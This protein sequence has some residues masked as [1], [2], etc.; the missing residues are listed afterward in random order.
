MTRPLSLERYQALTD[1]LAKDIR[2]LPWGAGGQKG[3]VKRL[4]GLI[5][6]NLKNATRQQRQRLEEALVEL[7]AALAIKAS[8]GQPDRTSDALA[9]WID[10]F[11]VTLGPDLLATPERRQ[12]WLDRSRDGARRARGKAR[13]VRHVKIGLAEEQWAKIQQLGAVLGA[14]TLSDSVASIVDAFDKAGKA[15]PVK[16]A[17]DRAKATQQGPGRRPEQATL[18]DLIEPPV[19][20]PPKSGRP[21][22]RAKQR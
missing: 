16:P 2:E 5:G 15:E 12:I 22:G 17:P 7:T 20:I 6:F 11:C 10:R 3:D 1:Q 9:R 8:E 13:D 19:V 4:A 18:L 21:R 14:T